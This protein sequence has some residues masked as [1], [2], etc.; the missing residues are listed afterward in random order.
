M[1][2]IVIQEI[3]IVEEVKNNNSKPITISLYDCTNKIGIY[4]VDVSLLSK[5]L[6]L[7]NFF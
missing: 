2:V 6:W 7:F 5:Y 1:Q 4:L 3:L